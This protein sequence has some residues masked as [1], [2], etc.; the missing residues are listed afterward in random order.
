MPAKNILFLG[1]GDIASRTC[2]LLPDHRLVGVA[3]SLKTPPAVVEF[4]QGAADGV[5]ILERLAVQTF[6]AAVITLTPTEYSDKAYQVAYVDTVNALV[7][8]WQRGR[9]PR[10]VIFISSTSVYHQCD[11]QWVDE[12]SATSPTGFAGQRLLEAEQCLQ[13]SGLPLC[14]VRFAGIYGPGRDFLIRQVRSGCGG[15]DAF[16]NRIH[17]QDCAGIIAFLLQRQW[18]GQPVASMYLGCDSMP[19]PGSQ[20]RRWLADKMGVD[21]RALQPSESGRGGN[22]RCSNKRLLAAGFQLRYPSYREGYTELL[23]G[24]VSG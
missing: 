17:A 1:F 9:A 10:L 5:A 18:A 22:K 13:A 6:D 23:D 12:D 24:S 19:A 3:R 8:Q 16:T 15:N 2:A 7:Q 21:A 4:W 20:V 11:G 14:I